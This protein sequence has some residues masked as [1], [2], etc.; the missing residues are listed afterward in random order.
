GGRLALELL[1]ANESISLL[2]CSA[3]PGLPDNDDAGRR[4]RL[5]SDQNWAQRF[6]NEEWSKVLTDWNAQGVF[7]A[8][9]FEPKRK[10]EEFDRESVALSLENWGWARQRDCHPLI[11][12]KGAQICA[13]VGDRDKIY[14]Q[15]WEP[16]ASSVGYFRKIPG[17]GHRLLFEA[18]REV[19]KALQAVIDRRA[20]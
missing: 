6:R 1:R 20:H 5:Q 12:R 9:C 2:V 11:R 13:L 19:A 7:S 3:G 17:A 16:L 8:D 18:P 10:E 15:R 4:A 14:C